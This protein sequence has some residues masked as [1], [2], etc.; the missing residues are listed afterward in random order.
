MFDRIRQ[1]KFFPLFIL[2]LV[3]GI[4]MSVLI[5]LNSA[6]DAADQK[7]FADQQ[8]QI[9]ASQS[10]VPTKKKLSFGVTDG[11]EQIGKTPGISPYIE[12]GDSEIIFLNNKY[13]YVTNKGLI[14]GSDSF[15]PDSTYI[16]PENKVLVNQPYRSYIYD[17]RTGLSETLPETIFSV[18]PEYDQDNQI[19][20]YYFLQNKN[21]KI[22]VK[23][24]ANL[25][26]SGVEIVTSVDKDKLATMDQV[27]LRVMGSKAY[28]FEYKLFRRQKYEDSLVN[29][30]AQK[31]LSI[32]ST[33]AEPEL[34][35]YLP[36]LQSIQFSKNN[37]LYTT[38]LS[39]P[40]NFTN[41]EQNLI[42]FRQPKPTVNSLDFTDALIAKNASGQ[43]LASRCNFRQDEKK[44]ICL[45]KEQKIGA[46]DP[47][48]KDLFMEYDLES[49]SVDFLFQSL[50]IAGESIH[51][52][53]TN[54]I[55]IFGQGNNN[56]YKIIGQ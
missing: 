34:K 42:D 22:Y 39:N 52:S 29:P 16:L 55:Y 54:E 43:I 35:F 50:N 44:I 41:L 2:F 13:N 24:A 4:I 46:F 6:K 49:I 45:L 19:I 14:Q 17:S 18:V 8:A 32:Y 21:D 30:V 5:Y 47:D 37:L 20:Q 33:D 56:L 25:N 10:V 12:F 9:L 31:N 38:I 11:V 7:A 53:P 1:S 3:L 28:L 23:K 15:L 40:N 36:D 27:E 51:Y 26:F 48:A